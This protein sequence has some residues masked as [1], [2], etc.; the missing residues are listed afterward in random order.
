MSLIFAGTGQAVTKFDFSAAGSPV[1]AGWTAAEI[2]NGSDGTISVATTGLDGVTVT[3]DSRN[4]PAWTGGGA[5]AAMWRDFIFANGSFASRPA[6]GLR[7]IISGLEP[8]TTYRLTL[9]AFDA[10][11]GRQAD[12]FDR[13]AD[14]G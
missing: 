3:L 10:S 14:C 12:G 4:R 6:S 11:S 13:A 7:L 9:W 1:Q 2:G 5:E 8:D